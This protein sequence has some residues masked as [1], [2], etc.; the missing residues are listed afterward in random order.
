MQQVS[1]I[2]IIALDKT[3]TALLTYIYIY[4]VKHYIPNGLHT[5]RGHSMEARASQLR[6]KFNN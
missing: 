2:R 3:K 4:I 1:G 6:C 5:W